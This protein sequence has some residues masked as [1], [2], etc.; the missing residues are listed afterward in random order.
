MDPTVQTFCSKDL[1]GGGGAGREGAGCPAGGTEGP[2]G[3]LLHSGRLHPM[4]HRPWGCATLPR[5]E[6]QPQSWADRR[7]LT[8][9]HT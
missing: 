1:M 4:A 8:K 2:T 5:L 7:L 3:R 9:A 6:I